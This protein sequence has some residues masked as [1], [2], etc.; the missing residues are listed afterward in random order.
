MNKS[1][2]LILVVIVFVG[3]FLVSGV[4]NHAFG[5]SGT[6]NGHEYV[7]LGLPSGTKWAACNVGA[8]KPEECGNYFAWGEI[9]TKKK[10]MEKTK[11]YTDNPIVL[12]SK[13]D[14]A[15][16]NLGVGWRMPTREEMQELVDNCDTTWTKQ[17]GVKGM[18]FTSRTNGN[19]I[20]LPAAGYHYGSNLSSVGYDGDYWSSSLRSDDMDYAWGLFFDANG[21]GVDNSHRYHGFSVRAVCTSLAK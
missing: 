7:D 14:A 1:R 21:Y 16:A 20:F 6:L 15:T 13:D 18:M 12:S 10:Y 4:S 8:N 3:A 17:N 5:Q 9:K 11:K 2:F 19:N